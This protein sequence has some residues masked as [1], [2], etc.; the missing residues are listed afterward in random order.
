MKLGI[1]IV[2]P[3]VIVIL[4]MLGWWTVM[5][6]PHPIEKPPGSKNIARDVSYGYPWEFGI[7]ESDVAGGFPCSIDVWKPRY[8][9]LDGVIWAAVIGCGALV[10]F[11]VTKVADPNG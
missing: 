2:R 9:V 6:W 7:D 1:K 4:S 5:F 10:L 8:F 11:R 3:A